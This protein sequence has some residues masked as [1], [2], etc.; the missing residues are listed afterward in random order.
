M[1]F[2]GLSSTP[3]T[4]NFKPVLARFRD[5]TPPYLRHLPKCVSNRRLDPADPF[6][7]IVVMWRR[8]GLMELE[9]MAHGAIQGRLNRWPSMV[10]LW[11][12]FV[13]DILENIWLKGYLFGSVLS[14]LIVGT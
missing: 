3:C 11:T 6:V 1:L 12:V 10:R 7:S 8:R 2:C 13:I 14:Q 4:W 5:H 9:I